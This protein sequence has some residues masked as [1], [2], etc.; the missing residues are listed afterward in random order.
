MVVGLVVLEEHAVQRV[1][2]VHVEVTHVADA[3]GG[4]RDGR[5]DHLHLQME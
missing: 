2:H 4:E 3:D 1:E 5:G